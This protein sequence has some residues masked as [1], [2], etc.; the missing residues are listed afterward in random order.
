MS[1]KRSDGAGGQVPTDNTPVEDQ[2]SI[3]ARGLRS[4][5]L[6]TN[7]IGS[8][9]PENVAAERVFFQSEPLLAG[10]VAASLEAFLVEPGDILSVTDARTGV[11]AQVLT[12]FGRTVDQRLRRVSFLALDTPLTAAGWTFTDNSQD[13]DDGN[14]VW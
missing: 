6:A 2:A 10:T 5:D 12:V 13:T 1:V 9:A 8:Y 7:Y 3:T 4:R 11:V 14:L